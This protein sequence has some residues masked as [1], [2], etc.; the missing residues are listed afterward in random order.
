VGEISVRLARVIHEGVDPQPQEGEDWGDFVKRRRGENETSGC[1]TRDQKSYYPRQDPK[2][3][4]LS[5]VM[6]FSRDIW[7][8]GA[9]IPGLFNNPGLLRGLL[10]NEA[11]GLGIGG[12]YRIVTKKWGDYT[13]V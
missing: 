6:A 2:I 10:I 1:R 3:I 4:L 8:A 12:G 13:L 11:K 7:G 5:G 9:T